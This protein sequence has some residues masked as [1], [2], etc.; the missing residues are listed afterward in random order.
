MTIKNI[1]EGTREMIPEILQEICFGEDLEWDCQLQMAPTSQ[2]P[3]PMVA[4][5]LTM[6]SGL[7]GTNIVGMFMV[8]LP[9]AQE[10]EALTR[11]MR[12]QF[13]QLL[14]QRSQVLAQQD[15]QASQNGQGII[16]PGGHANG[17]G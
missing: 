6:G 11:A 10:R 9:V 8:P 4:I 15:Q 1:M 17:V 12:Q 3:Q 5:V 14:Q 13:E 7:L 2:G 16:L